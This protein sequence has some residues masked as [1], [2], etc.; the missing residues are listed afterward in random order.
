MIKTGVR[1]VVVYNPANGDTVQVSKIAAN[2]FSFVQ[3]P[4]GLG[5]SSS[6]GVVFDQADIS[7][8]RFEFFDSDGTIYNQLDSWREARTRVSLIATGFGQNVQWNEKDH[9]IIKRAPFGGMA[10]SRGD[11]YIF[12]LRRE[13]HG[14]HMIYQ[15]TNLLAHLGGTGAAWT[16]ETGTGVAKGYTAT[17][18]GTL[19]WVSPDTQQIQH[20]AADEGIYADIIFPVQLSGYTYTFSV[21]VVTLH[22]DT[23]ETKAKIAAYDFAG[24]EL[25]STST[26]FTSTG[27][28][29]MTLTPTGAVHR[30]RVHPLLTPSGV[31]T[32]Q[33]AA[34]K[35]PCL[36]I[37]GS[38]TYV[39]N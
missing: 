6:T 31:T 1:H 21:N 15:Q 24:T 23:S 12:E 38:T 29:S 34:T 8:C 11:K 39:H 25:S 32:F 18:A 10:D 14:R 37:D 19:S 28:G 35:F 16:E 27:V 22:S 9:F 3:E 4:L 5:E 20:S 26:E 7:V 30:L 33:A 36:R 17:G 13:G 2:T